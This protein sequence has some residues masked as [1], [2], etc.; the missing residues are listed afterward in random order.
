M[1]HGSYTRTRP[2]TNGRLCNAVLRQAIAGVLMTGE[3]VE[4][5]I[6]PLFMPG[7]VRMFRTTSSYRCPGR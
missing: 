7:L 1:N 4:W 6:D 5:D 3:R 2:L